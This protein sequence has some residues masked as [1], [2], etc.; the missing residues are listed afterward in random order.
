ML[1]ASKRK[2][3]KRKRVCARINEKNDIKKEVGHVVE[4]AE[5]VYQ[6]GVQV[7]I[8]QAKA[9]V[10]VVVVVI[11]VIVNIDEKIVKNMAKIDEVVQQKRGKIEKTESTVKAE[12]IQVEVAEAGVE[13]IAPVILVVRAGAGAGA[14][15][16][17]VE[18]V[19]VT[20]EAVVEVVS[21][22]VI[23]VIVIIKKIHE[24]KM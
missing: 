16:A 20:V 15:E 1:K 2:R 3:E 9:G 14:G 12:A 8:Q 24:E 23:Q 18:V 22:R 17:I 6:A 7:Q 4:A 5:A 11:V 19:I 10:E 13:V 21:V